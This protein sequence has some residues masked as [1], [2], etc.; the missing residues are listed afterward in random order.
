MNAVKL[1]KLKKGEHFQYA[2][3]PSGEPSGPIYIKGRPHT[4]KDNHSRK[5]FV[6]FIYA[7]GEPFHN[8]FVGYADCETMVFKVDE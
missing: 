6:T 7:P 4:D 8:T 3:Y 1:Y 5:M 2:D